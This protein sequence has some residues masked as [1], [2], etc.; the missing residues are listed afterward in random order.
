LIGSI[1]A[2]Q[3]GI[4]GDEYFEKKNDHSVIHPMAVVLWMPMTA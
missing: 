2:I 1:P 3:P 4:L